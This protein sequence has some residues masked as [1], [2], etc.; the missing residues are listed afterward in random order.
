VHFACTAQDN[1][2]SSLALLQGGKMVLADNSVVWE[3]NPPKA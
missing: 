3:Q 1:K 2:T